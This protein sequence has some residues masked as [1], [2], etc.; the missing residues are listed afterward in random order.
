MWPFVFTAYAS[1][2]STIKKINKAI[3]NPLIVLMFAIA[4]VYFLYGLYEF[5]K[6]ADSS[7]ARE[8]GK[9]HIIWGLIGMFIMVA[10]YFIMEL[11]L[12]TLGIGTDQI[13]IT[14]DSID[15]NLPPI[16]E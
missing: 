2:D 6:D 14:P 12:G 9:R 16:Q 10:V 7:D 8:T 3:I 13:N 15:V 1:L 5:I 4:A 11:I